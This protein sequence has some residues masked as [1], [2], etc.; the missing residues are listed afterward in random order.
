MKAEPGEQ[1]GIPESVV[2]S[3][4]PGTGQPSSVDKAL[5]NKKQ[6]VIEVKSSAD[7]SEH[8]YSTVSKTSNPSELSCY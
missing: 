7:I 6:S 3:A 4:E 2:E 8:A 5:L 1:E